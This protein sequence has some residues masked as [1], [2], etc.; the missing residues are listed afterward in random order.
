LPC[1]MT[2]R[3]PASNKAAVAADAD[4]IDLL[5]ITGWNVMDLS[6]G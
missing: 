4:S 1:A 6:P 3:A 5:V 2:G